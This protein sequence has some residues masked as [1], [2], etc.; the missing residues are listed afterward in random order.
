M[1]EKTVME[2]CRDYWSTRTDEP[3]RHRA[4]GK[5]VELEWKND[6]GVHQL[7]RE[8]REAI[9]SDFKEWVDSRE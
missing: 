3:F 2:R 8:D 7:S 9:V 4:A 5:V 6:D 1:A